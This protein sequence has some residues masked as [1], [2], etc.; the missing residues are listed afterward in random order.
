MEKDSG[1]IESG[2]Q[3]AGTG[4][5]VD[6]LGE[7]IEDAFTEPDPLRAAFT[8]NE[9]QPDTVQLAPSGPNIDCARLRL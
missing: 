9:L 6:S 3:R 2:A 5:I 4:A 8:M 7:R 1:R